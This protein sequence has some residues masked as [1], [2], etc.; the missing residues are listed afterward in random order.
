[1][2]KTFDMDISELPMYPTT[3]SYY[4]GDF[5]VPKIPIIVVGSNGLIVKTSI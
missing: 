4:D 1:M 5:P 2:G 3:I